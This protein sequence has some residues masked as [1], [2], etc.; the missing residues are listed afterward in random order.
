MKGLTILGSTGSIGTQALEIVTLN[1]EQIIV[2]AIQCDTNID[3]LEAQILK[4]NPTF[5]LVSNIEQ[6]KKLKHR[7]QGTT[8]ILVGNEQMTLIVTAP[9]VDIVLTSVMG[10]VGLMP[11][12]EAI[13]FGKTIAL[14]NKETLVAAG[15]LVMAEAKKYG[16][17]IIPVDSEHSAIFQCL[18]GATQNEVKSILLTA[19]GG[20]FRQRP[21]DTFSDIKLEDAL[22]HPNWSMGKKITIDS[23]T[24]MNKGLEVIEAK[25]LFDLSPQQIQVVI[26]PQS[27]IHSM[28]EFMDTSI[29]AQLGNPDMKLPIHYALFYPKRVFSQL[30]A[31]SFINYPTLTFEQPDFGKFPCLQLAFDALKSGG[32]MPTVLNAANEM[33]VQ[34]FLNQEIRYVDIPA[35]VTT[36]MS[37]HQVIQNPSL[38]VVMEADRQARLFRLR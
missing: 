31:F 26:H 14:A 10:S 12:L 17:K 34:A 33:A 19:S 22:K 8:E 23:A 29:L 32:T 15:E 3:L 7:Y 4:F 5:A 2:F 20:P 1:P 27:I 25:W 24:L 37:Q 9:E 36:V 11:T 35:W 13:R 21:V 16:A 18:Q 30:D 28:V 6:G 38:E